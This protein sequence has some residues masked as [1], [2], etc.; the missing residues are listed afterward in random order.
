MDSGF[1]L[2]RVNRYT[3]AKFPIPDFILSRKP[4]EFVDLIFRKHGA[5]YGNAWPPST[6]CNDRKYLFKK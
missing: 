1:V 6:R 2:C 3:L 5:N 4:V